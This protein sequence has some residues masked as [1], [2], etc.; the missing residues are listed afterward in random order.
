MKPDPLDNGTGLDLAGAPPTAHAVKDAAMRTEGAAAAVSELYQ[1][2]AVG[3][4]RVAVLN[5][6][7]SALRRRAIRSRRVLYELPAP[8]VEAAVLGGE[9]GNHYRPIPWPANIV[10]AAW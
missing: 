8:S 1:A 6:C 2:A 4:I 10:G 9:S 5:A 7:R 3:L